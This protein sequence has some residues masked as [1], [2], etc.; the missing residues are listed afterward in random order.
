[1]S[2]QLASEL[3]KMRSTRTA[4]A[5][6]VS[7]LALVLVV[8]VLHGYALPPTRL[9]TAAD[10]VTFL[11][12][13]GEVLA[14]LFAGLLGAMSFTGEIRYGTIRPTL[15]VTPRRARIVG[16]KCL[17]GALAGLAVGMVATSA[18]AVT[19][20]VVLAVRGLES[21]LDSNDYLL[22]IGGGAVAAALWAMIGLGIGVIV[23][24]QVPTLVGLVTWVLFI[25]TVFVDNLP[26]VGRYAPS[27]L[28]QALSGLRP[29]TLL[30]PALAALLLALYGAVAIVA[31]TAV[32][33]RC[34]FA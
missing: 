15:L 31:G 16:A 9:A 6:V 30:P 20:R 4:T 11:I 28:G 23:R 26:G 27:A 18:A 32:T 13:W 29:D 5:V 21:T 25:E 17:A 22:F 7:M 3:L 14:A 24:S 8:V 34:D 19:G 12:G 10:Q 2:A 1:M 33:T